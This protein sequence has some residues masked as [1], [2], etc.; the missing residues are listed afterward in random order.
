MSPG[1]R[2]PPKSIPYAPLGDPATQ[3]D[4]NTVDWVLKNVSSVRVTARERKREGVCVGVM[5]GVCGC[6][7]WPVCIKPPREVPR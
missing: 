2:G 3:G 1:D 6:P 4:V 5:E 7:E